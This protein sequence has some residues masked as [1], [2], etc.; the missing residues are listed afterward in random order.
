M[1][2]LGV[3]LVLGGTLFTFIGMIG[4]EQGGNPSAA[5]IGIGAIL[6]GVLCFKGQGAV[7]RSLR[8]RGICDACV[9]RGRN[10]DG[11]TCGSCGGSG[12]C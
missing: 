10:T 12:R 7:D 5:V 8:A 4:I 2:C 11:F 3:V 1:G 9:G 6:I